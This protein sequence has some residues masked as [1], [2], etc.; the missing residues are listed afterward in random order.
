MIRKLK[1]KERNTL[2]TFDYEL[3]LGP[4]SGSVKKCLLEPTDLLIGLFDKYAIKGA[5]FFVDTS[6]LIRLKEENNELC[7]RDF[8][9]IQDQIRTLIKKGHYVFPHIHP[10]W[11]D[12]EYDTTINE[13]KL[14]N[15]SKYRFHNATPADR[16]I[17]FEKSIKILGEIIKPENEN[18]PINGYRAGGWSIQPFEDFEPYFKKYGIQYEFSVVPGFKNLSDAQFFDFRGAPDKNIFKFESDPNKEKKEGNY[19]EYTISTLAVTKSMYWM[20]KVWG[21][22]LWKTGQ[23]SIGDGIGVAIKDESVVENRK[24]MIGSNTM[25]MISIELLTKVKLKHYKK[26]IRDNN[27]MHF[28]S[29][30]KM[31]SMH[32]IQSFDDFLR[33]AVSNYK[34]IT[35]FAHFKV[36]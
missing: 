36:Q 10:H 35:D 26:F 17:L 14:F 9:L 4:K 34:L 24:E 23:R 5:V 19:T 28:I 18:Y 32:N 22:Y 27:Y 1:K 15:Y 13:W 3:F 29:H 6:Y 25:E 21:K 20:G 11:I 16:N 8:T 7:K 31:L 30:P 33:S 12:A 2:F